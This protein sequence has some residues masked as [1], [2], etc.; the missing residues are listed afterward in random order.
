MHLGGEQVVAPL[1]PG[2]DPTSADWRD[3]EGNP[4]V[5]TLPE[6]SLLRTLGAAQR[7]AWNAV[8]RR[9]VGPSGDPPSRTTEGVILPLPTIASRA[10]IIGKESRHLGAGRGVFEA[11]E[12]VD[13]GGD[14][15]L[16]KVIAAARRLSNDSAVRWNLI[17]ATEISERE[18]AYLLTG[19]RK[20]RPE[21][22][23]R[24][25]HAAA[26]AARRE[27]LRSELSGTHPHEDAD[28]IAAFL[29]TAEPERRCIFCGRA[30]V[31]KQGHW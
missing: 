1:H 28:V 22:R 15:D 7:R 3:P 11:P 16:P 23:E 20:P 14:D 21:T 29:D 8:D 13:Y 4:V 2:F 18:F 10:R 27:L 30:L 24:L 17:Q 26:R 6:T 25:I 19:D 31:G 9:V 12:Y 5:A